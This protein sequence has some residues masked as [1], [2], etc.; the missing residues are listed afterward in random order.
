[1]DL[2]I[3][4]TVRRRDA[5]KVR[6]DGF[7]QDYPTVHQVYQKLKESDIQPIF[8]I[9]GNESTILAYQAIVSN[10]DDISATLEELDGDSSK[11]IDLIQRSYD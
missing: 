10:W 9:S 2:D 8:A 7:V 3:F 11:I 6:F 5:Q 4:W 1:M